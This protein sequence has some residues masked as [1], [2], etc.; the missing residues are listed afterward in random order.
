MRSAVLILVVAAFGSSVALAQATPEELSLM[1][2]ELK[3]QIDIADSTRWMMWTGIASAVFAFLGFVGVMFTLREQRLLTTSQERAALLIEECD[4]DFT[5]VE[6]YGKQ[7]SLTFS[8]RN[9]GRTRADHVKVAVTAAES[10]GV[11]KQR[12]GVRISSGTYHLSQTVDA[13]SSATDELELP[14]TV[15]PKQFAK[16]KNWNG[17]TVKVSFR[18]R[19]VFGQHHTQESWMTVGGVSPA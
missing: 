2:S 10:G 19:D 1:N 3:V 15:T 6:G 11:A 14:S 9:A 17:Y 18:Y 7:F 13:G 12:R 8:L 5:P 16:L 4:V